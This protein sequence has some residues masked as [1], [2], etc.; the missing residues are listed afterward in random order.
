MSLGYDY[1]CTTLSQEGRIYQLEYAEKAIE[2]APTAMGLVFSDGVVLAGEK[3]RGNKTIVSGSNPT[4]YN[5]A[6]NIGMAVCG[7][8]PDGRN[9][10]SRAKAEAQSYLKNFGVEISGKILAE[11]LAQYVQSHTL[12]W[13]MRPFGAVSMISS[14]DYDGQYHL[15]MVEANGNFFEYYSCVHGKGRQFV[16]TEVEKDNFSLKTK[17]AADGLYDVVKVLVRSYEGEKETEYDL[18]VIT[19]VNGKNYHQIVDKKYVKELV[20]KAKIQVEEE[21]KMEVDL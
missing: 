4:I 3:I 19:N 13:S 5:V 21:R 1:S 6:P 12:Y 15:Y 18:S 2:N 16:K 17:K 8:L 14:F 10:V 20:A 9:L 7:H 11:R